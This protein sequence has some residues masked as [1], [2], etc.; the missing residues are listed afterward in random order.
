LTIH[1]DTEAA[2]DRRIRADAQRN[3]DVVLAA[4][5]ELFAAMGVDAAVRDI[6]ARAGVGVA[7]LY[8]RFPKR[9]DLVAAVFRHEVDACA[10]EAATLAAAHSPDEALAL[11][12]KRYT[13]FIAT[14][15]GLAAA[16]HSGDPAYAALPDYFRASFEP[17][18]A[19]LLA[20]AAATGKIRNDVAPYDL[21]RAIGN[22][23]VTSDA[24]GA[25]HT[26]RMVDLL[27]NGL[28]QR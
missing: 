13:G 11:W 24:D 23:S 3:E 1:P 7:T 18:L 5:K 20:A 6:A 10:A 4:A 8:R 28:Q 12:L 17:A 9:S 2:P 25:A 27:I 22:L 26:H 21:L 15:K 19:A 16:L 14:K